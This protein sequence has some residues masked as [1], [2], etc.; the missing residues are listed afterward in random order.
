MILNFTFFFFFFFFF[1]FLCIKKQSFSLDRLTQV[2]DHAESLNIFHALFW[3][4]VSAFYINQQIRIKKN[5]LTL[6]GL[7]VVLSHKFILFRL[8][9]TFRKVFFFF[10]SFKFLSFKRNV[11]IKN[12][13]KQKS[14]KYESFFK[15]PKKRRF[16]HI[17]TIITHCFGLQSI[18]G[19]TLF[20]YNT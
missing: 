5:A 1:L 16:Y 3:L 6:I 10:S 13:Q 2:L 19:Y 18:Y 4:F 7:S 20:G 14:L 12:Y 17:K 15:T 11:I 9:R 8:W